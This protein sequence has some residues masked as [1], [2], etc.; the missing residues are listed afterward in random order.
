MK[1]RHGEGAERTVDGLFSSFLN[2]CR[3]WVPALAALIIAQNSLE[4]RQK[5]QKCRQGLSRTSTGTLERD[6][7]SRLEPC[8]LQAIDDK[9]EGIKQSSCCKNSKEAA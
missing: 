1:A 9:S 2:L 7:L 6:W 3:S 5:W 8:W 4:T